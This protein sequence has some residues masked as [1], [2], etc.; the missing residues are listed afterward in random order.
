MH[1]PPNVRVPSYTDLYG[2]GFGVM[3]VCWITSFLLL[4]ILAVVKGLHVV[5]RDLVWFGV[6][7]AW[8][9]AAATF[10]DTLGTALLVPLP[11]LNVLALFLTASLDAVHPKN[12]PPWTTREQLREAR[13]LSNNA[14][15]G[16]DPWTN[17]LAR[18]HAGVHLR[19]FGWVLPRWGLVSYLVLNGLMTGNGV[20]LLV[21]GFRHEDPALIAIGLNNISLFAGFAVFALALRA[22][23]QHM[24]AF[25]DL[26]DA[27]QRR[28]VR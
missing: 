13:V 11:L 18:V 12:L 7:P 4:V 26:Y 19:S 21:L 8:A 16:G 2:P 24:R 10:S 28:T 23:R 20:F 6:D 14:V 22:R 17:F 27:A 15:M 5:M 1:Q 25:C 3:V 9:D